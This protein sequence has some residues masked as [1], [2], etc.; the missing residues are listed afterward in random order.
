MTKEEL[1]KATRIKSDTLNRYRRGYTIQSTTKKGIVNRKYPPLLDAEDWHK[2]GRFIIYH[3][4]ALTKIR[5]HL[6]RLKAKHKRSAK[7]K[8]IKAQII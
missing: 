7:I 1:M 8:A 3:S 2:K 6:D 4:S 5:E